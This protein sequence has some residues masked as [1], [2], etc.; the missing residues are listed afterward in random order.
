MAK[1]YT[2]EKIVD[3]SYPVIL[4]PDNIVESYTINYNYVHEKRLIIPKDMWFAI[5]YSRCYP[6]QHVDIPRRKTAT[7]RE[8]TS[9]GVGGLGLSKDGYV[10]GASRSCAPLIRR[11][12]KRGEEWKGKKDHHHDRSKATCDD[13]SIGS[14]EDSARLSLGY[15][16]VTGKHNVGILEGKEYE[17]LGLRRQGG[18]SV[19]PGLLPDGVDYRATEI[20]PPQV[21]MKCKRAC[22][23]GNTGLQNFRKEAMR[24][25]LQRRK[26]GG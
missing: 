15:A 26:M 3:Q 21:R 20:S 17:S 18:M 13:E 12:T 14:P 1:A 2:V 16:T 24:E 5:W 8:H 9:T 19:I 4:D 22:V 7:E 25:F 11:T 10:S 23:T 6:R